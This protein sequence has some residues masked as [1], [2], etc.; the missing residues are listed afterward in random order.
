MEDVIFYHE[1]FYRQIE[2]ISSAN[3]FKAHRDITENI[4]IDINPY[5]FLTA[6]ER[7]EHVITTEHL[8]ISLNSVSAALSPFT[9]KYFSSV[10]TGYS[11]S[12]KIQKNTIALGFERI[13]IFFQTNEQDIIKNIWLCQSTLLPK[14]TYCK[15]FFQALITLGQDY[16]LILVDWNEEIVVRLTSPETLQN[17]LR[18]VFLFKFD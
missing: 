6:T 12:I 4:N 11:N 9:I 13:A 15:N 7:S 5:G 10:T 1:D 3:Y 14:D 16:D 8:N 18:E 2:L 17:Y